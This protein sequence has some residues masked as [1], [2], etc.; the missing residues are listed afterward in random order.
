MPALDDATRLAVIALIE[1]AEEAG[2]GVGFVPEGD[3]WRVLHVGL[4]WPAA[5]D[6]YQEMTGE[7]SNAYTLEDAAR[8]ALRPLA[9]L[10]EAWQNYLANRED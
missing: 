5:S 8:G 6:Q 4:N 2:I 1:K 9:E 3:G 7:L 10:S